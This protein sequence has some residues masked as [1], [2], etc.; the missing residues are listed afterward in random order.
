MDILR[1]KLAKLPIL[2]KDL[3]RHTPIPIL[4]SLTYAAT[5]GY[6]SGNVGDIGELVIFLG[7]RTMIKEEI[8]ER[9]L[10]AL[11]QGQRQVCR[12]VIEQA[13]Q[14]GTLA[15]SVYLDIVW[16]VMA[17]IEKLA[18]AER[19]SPTQEHMATRIN[20]TIIDQLQNKLPHKPNRNKKIV[21][22]CARDELQELGAQILADLFE[23]D[24]WEVKFLGGGLSNDDILAFVNE[25]G[26]DILLIY[27]T[28]PKQAP[29]IRQLTDSIRDVD[30]RP[31][32][33][34]MVSGGL[35]NR[36][37]GLW[38]EIGA[39]LFAANALEALQQAS[40]ESAAEPSEER[41]SR[42]RKRYQKM[43]KAQLAQSPE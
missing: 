3:R 36:A 10:D 9:Y 30:A 34:I 41:A 14:K 4:P 20:R 26:P 25:H 43:H 24:G 5:Q 19:I 17:E 40:S 31:S 29:Q 16:P 28:A 13:L 12:S 38:E 23:S 8:L 42:R 35:F 2:T 11:L 22:C 21:I 27:G 32:M 37:E 1:Q 39:D 33:R 6:K 15:S 7:Y 18:R